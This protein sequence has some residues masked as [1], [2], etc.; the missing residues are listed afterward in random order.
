MSLS[1][2]RYQ[3]PVIELRDDESFVLAEEA[4]QRMK[5]KCG[6]PSIEMLI[7]FADS[8]NIENYLAGSKYP[9]TSSDILFST[10]T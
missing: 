6:N 3:A 2:P 7:S 8:L 4:T 5:E 9:F 1:S 10:R